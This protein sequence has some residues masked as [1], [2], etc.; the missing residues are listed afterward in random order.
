MNWIFIAVGGLL[1]VVVLKIIFKALKIA[2]F[3]MIIFLLIL[4][5]WLWQ[6]GMIFK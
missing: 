6:Q 4:V 5:F 2:F 3:L 1:L